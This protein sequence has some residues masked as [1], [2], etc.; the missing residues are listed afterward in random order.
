MSY[1]ITVALIGHVCVDTD[2]EDDAIEI[3]NSHPEDI[4]WSENY[5]VMNCE[6]SD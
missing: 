2:N 5:T 1:R 3:A 4:K 6:E